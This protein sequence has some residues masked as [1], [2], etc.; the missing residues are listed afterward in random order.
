MGDS[1]SLSL[2]TASRRVVPFLY[3]LERVARLSHVRDVSGSVSL[4]AHDFPNEE[5]ESQKAGTCNSGRLLF[6]G[7]DFFQIHQFPNTDP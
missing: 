5:K 3:E 7:T 4:F 2:D 6:G 1:A